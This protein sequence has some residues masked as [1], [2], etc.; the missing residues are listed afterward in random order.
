MNSY[1]TCTLSIL[2]FYSLGGACEFVGGRGA[3]CSGGRYVIVY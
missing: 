2:L 1:G 3:T